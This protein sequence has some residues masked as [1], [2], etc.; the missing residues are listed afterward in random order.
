MAERAETLRLNDGR[1]VGIAEYGHPGGFPV[2]AFHGIPGSR[3]TFAFADTV[4][5]RLQIRLIAPER[6]GIGLS[7]P[8]AQR[9][10]LDWPGDVGQLVEMLGLS[11]FGV[12][13]LSGGG[14]YALAVAAR[15]AGRVAGTAI[16]SGMGPVDDPWVLEHAS[17]SQ[18]L[19]LH[20]FRDLPGFI[21]ALVSLAG[22]GLMR[23][24]DRRLAQLISR[25][26]EPGRE[27]LRHLDCASLVFEP[28]REGYRQG[29]AGVAWDLKLMT[30]PWGFAVEE[31]EGQVLLW[32][33]V[34]DLD[35]PVLLARA[36]ARR[37]PQCEA[38]FVADAGHLWILD[39]IEEVLAGVLRIPSESATSVP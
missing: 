2:L 27:A 13:G 8:L 10:I 36:V 15:L 6:P 32:H 30:R 31:V 4:A 22:F 38:H 35:V 18:R 12:I 14:P 5:R 16:V 25:V 20:L 9:E 21:P 24:S 28:L 1:L 29:S 3:R 34:D 33:G 7:S 26:P 39:H 23:L 19:R 17:R 11:S 37:L